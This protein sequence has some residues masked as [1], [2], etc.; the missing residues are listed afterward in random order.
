MSVLLRRRPFG[1]IV[2]VVLVVLLLLLY[3]AQMTVVLAWAF[4]LSGPGLKLHRMITGRPF[5]V[6]PAD[7]TRP[8]PRFPLGHRR[9]EKCND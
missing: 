5:H 4:A 9:K 1:H 2:L 3:P 7:Q 6:G 8:R